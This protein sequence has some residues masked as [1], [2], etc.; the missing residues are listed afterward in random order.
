MGFLDDIFK[1]DKKKG[2]NTTGGG[3]GGLQNPFGGPRTFH[4][5]GQ[6]LGGSKPGRVIQI[7]LSNPGP[8][9]VRVS[10]V[11]DSSRECLGCRFPFDPL[12]SHPM[13]FPAKFRWRNDPTVVE[14]PS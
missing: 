10:L 6:S 5:Q 3:G 7:T 12:S 8:L 13:V 1:G 11:V 4:G 9:G 2:G 14:R